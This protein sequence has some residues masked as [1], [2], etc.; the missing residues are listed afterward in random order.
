RR[1]AWPLHKDDTLSR[2]GGPTGLN[3]YF[4]FYIL[5]PFVP[6]NDLKL[7]RGLETRITKACMYTVY[8]LHSPG[9]IARWVSPL[10]C[11]LAP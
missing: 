8:I 10:K 1:L 4:F 9:R 11:L 6:R 7:A 5:W 3:L 2:N